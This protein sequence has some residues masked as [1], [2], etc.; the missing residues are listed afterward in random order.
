MKIKTVAIKET[1]AEKK[2]ASFWKG[3]TEVH[4]PFRHIYAVKSN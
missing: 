2:S 4:G 1:P 3:W